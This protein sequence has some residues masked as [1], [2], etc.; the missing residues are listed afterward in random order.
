MAMLDR[1]F[2]A[3]DVMAALEAEVGHVIQCRKT[4]IVTALN[5]YV[6]IPEKNESVDNIF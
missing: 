1:A 2:F 4:D 6:V 3:A 5:E